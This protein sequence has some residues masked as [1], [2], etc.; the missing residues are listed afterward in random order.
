MQ[1]ACLTILEISNKNFK[2]NSDY[3]T[4]NSYMNSYA[5]DAWTTKQTKRIR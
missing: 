3:S 5:N 4:Q 2:N 1:H